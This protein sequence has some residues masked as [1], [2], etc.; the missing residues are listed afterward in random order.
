MGRSRDLSNLARAGA[1]GTAN[2]ADNAVTTAKIAAGA[3]VTADIADANVTGAKLENSGVTAGAYGSASAIPVVTVDAK[4]RVTAA[5]TVAVTAGIT[6]QN[7][8]YT[9]SLVEAGPAL[10]GVS[11]TVD[12]GANRVMTGIRT[13]FQFISCNGYSVIY[14]RG[15]NIKNTA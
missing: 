4:G 9:G 5:S 11:T 6:A 1:V 12:L 2:I 8:S 14:V 7:C 15:Y 3:V 10:V 13:G